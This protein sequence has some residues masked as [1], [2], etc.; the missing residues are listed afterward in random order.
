MSTCRNHHRRLT[1]ADRI[2]R[3]ADA[4]VAAIR[5]RATTNHLARI[6]CLHNNNWSGLDYHGE[7]GGTIDN[8]TRRKL[9]EMANEM[10]HKM[11]HPLSCN[12]NL[13]SYTSFE[14]GCTPFSQLV[15]SHL[16]SSNN[17]SA[18]AEEETVRISS[19]V[20]ITNGSLL[21]YQTDSY[22][23]QVIISTTSYVTIRTTFVLV[24]GLLNIETPEGNKVTLSLYGEED[25]YFHPHPACNAGGCNVGSKVI[26]VA[27]G[28]VDIRG[29]PTVGS[30]AE[31][32]GYQE[33]CPAWEKLLDMSWMKSQVPSAAPSVVPSWSP[34]GSSLGM[35]T[36]HPAEN[37]TASVS[38]F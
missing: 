14:N 27:G 33:E 17:S 35:P 3:E 15:I 34:S 20:D 21:V 26:A 30:I 37:P 25:V 9:M 19:I 32:T 23:W 36:F 11:H 5:S 22:R 12:A 18:E 24:L 10:S 28:K 13:E 7:E 8:E 16:K 38:L 2:L 1:N 29:M 31:G 6:F 4:D